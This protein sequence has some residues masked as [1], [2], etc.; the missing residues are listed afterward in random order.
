M[1]KELTADELMRMH[2]MAK[3]F[4][5]LYGTTGMIDINPNDVHLRADVFFNTFGDREYEYIFDENRNVETYVDGVR[6]HAILKYETL[7]NLAR[8]VAE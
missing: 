3:E 8:E 2:V 7:G 5:K 6:Y 4:A 1:K